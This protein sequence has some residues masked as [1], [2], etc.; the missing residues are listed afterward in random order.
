MRPVSGPRVRIAAILALLGAFA[1]LG[2]TQVRER[3]WA[4]YESEMQDPVE[5][6][7]DAGRKGE[8][9][10]GRLRYRS[11]M[12]GGRF[13]ARW[14]IDANKGDRIFITLLRRLTRIDVQPIETIVDIDSD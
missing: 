11:P 5:D 13:Y 9:A 3:V 4:R 12:D 2:V 8:F 10:V 6:P 1:V 7:P 14:G